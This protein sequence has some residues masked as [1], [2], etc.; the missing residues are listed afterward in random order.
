M[1][2]ADSIW[3]YTD[4]QEKFLTKSLGLVP[5]RAKRGEGNEGKRPP[6]NNLI[7]NTGSR[8]EDLAELYSGLGTNPSRSRQPGAPGNQGSRH[9]GVQEFSR[10]SCGPAAAN[11]GTC[12]SGRT[13]KD[14]APLLLTRRR[15]EAVE[16]GFAGPA[17]PQVN[18]PVHAAH[19][20]GAADDVADGCREQIVP[21]EIPPGQ[22]RPAVL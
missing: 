19:H 15:G 12:Q 14:I 1:L 21:Q 3:G 6:F 17:R 2:S 16:R 13:R 11:R 9:R 20:Q 4:C 5:G 18:E 10:P 22:N 7:G 8:R